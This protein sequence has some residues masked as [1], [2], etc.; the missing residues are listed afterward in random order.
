MRV[1]LNRTLPCFSY[2]VLVACLGKVGHSAGAPLGAH[3][4]N[5]KGLRNVDSSR[6]INDLLISPII[7]FAFLIFSNIWLSNFSW[8]STMT[9]M[10]FSCLTC[11]NSVVCIADFLLGKYTWTFM[12]SVQTI[13]LQVEY[14]LLLFSVVHCTI[15]NLLTL[16]GKEE[17]NNGKSN[18]L[19]NS[20][21][22]LL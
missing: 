1:Y 13:R 20:S 10:S 12:H 5:G 19:P 21:P 15:Q 2:I 14:I 18:S 16:L 8:S 9:P 7:L 4:L 11:F 22:A 17:I 6:C 3:I